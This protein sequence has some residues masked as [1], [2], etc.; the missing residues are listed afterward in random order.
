MLMWLHCGINFGIILKKL[1]FSAI[2]L[3]K[4][5]TKASC[6]WDTRFIN[7]HRGTVMH[8][9][10]KQL[11]WKLK[12]SHYI[13]FSMSHVLNT[14]TRALVFNAY[15]KISAKGFPFQQGYH[16]PLLWPT[17]NLNW[18]TLEYN[19]SDLQ[20]VFGINY[21]KSCLVHFFAWLGIPETVPRE[22]SFRKYAAPISINFFSGKFP[23]HP[24]CGSHY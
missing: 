3:Y 24:R 19:T 12:T 15:H 17:S 14:K 22:R 20:T 5:L 6:S 7:S 13:L 16:V 9:H 23:L 8:I 18:Q 4:I 21:L 2:I 10:S 11:I 1:F